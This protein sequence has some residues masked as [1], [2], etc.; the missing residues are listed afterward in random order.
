MIQNTEAALTAESATD[1]DNVSQNFHVWF[2]WGFINAV[3]PMGLMLLAAIT[4]FLPPVAMF[5]AGLAGCSGCSG[6]AWYIAGMVW[7]FRASGKYASGDIV[8]ESFTEET[9]LEYLQDDE[10]PV[11]MQYSSGNFMATYYLIT[12]ILMGIC[13]GCCIIGLILQCCVGIA[14]MGSRD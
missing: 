12:W 10:S 6:L 5:F 9:W 2:L 1:I 4:S 14:I 8:P 3:G 7:R 13:C 11:N